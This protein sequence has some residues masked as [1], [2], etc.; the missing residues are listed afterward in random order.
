M[1]ILALPNGSLFEATSYLLK[2][3]G[4]WLA[5]NGRSFMA[6]INGVNMFDKVYILRPQDIPSA[7][8]SGVAQCGITGWDCVVEAAMENEVKKISELNYSKSS[9]KPVRIVVFGKIDV[10]MDKPNVKVT[11]EYPT[12]AKA[13]FKKARVDFSHGTTEAKVVCGMYDYGVGVVDTGRSLVDNGLIIVKEIL[14]APT[15][16][17]AKEETPEIKLFGKLLTGVLFAEDNQLLIMNVDA[18]IKEQV[19][20]ILPALRSPTESHLAD[21]SW[22]ISTVVAKAQLVNLM[23]EL[24]AM[25][26][27]GILQQDFNSN[28]F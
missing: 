12:L 27:T 15:V 13:V 4:I 7:V 17:I 14:I 9:R 3:I 24:G 23:L 22:S 1:R 6:E 28:P 26:V 21:G 10:L 20:K 5:V 25:G 2:K 18:A 8:K 16:L 19:I 11:A